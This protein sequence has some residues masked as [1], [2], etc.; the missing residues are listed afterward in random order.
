MEELLVRYIHFLGI[1]LLASM[2]VTENILLS[3]NLKRKTVEKLAIIDGIYGLSAIITLSAGLMLWL[4]VGKP[5]QFYSN[6]VIFHAK[7]GL[8][9]FV[10]L[11]SIF[12]TVFILKQRK[13]VNGEIVV[14]SHVILIKRTEAGLLL[15]LPL[16]AVLMARGY[17][18]T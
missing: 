6:N 16:L 5:S 10:G 14:P 12:P 2:L 8:F 9:V 3:K 1:M 11:L 7:L 13:S 18:L 15:V 4:A 17:G